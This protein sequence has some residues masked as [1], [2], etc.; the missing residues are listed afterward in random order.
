MCDKS[1][2]ELRSTPEVS[3]LEAGATKAN[4]EQLTWKG[5]IGEIAK[6]STL[7]LAVV[8]LFAYL[9]ALF[10]LRS[11]CGFFGIPPY[12]VNP[13]RPAIAWI[14]PHLISFLVIIVGG[15]LLGCFVV[16]FMTRPF[17]WLWGKIR[18]PPKKMPKRVE[19]PGSGRIILVYLFFASAF[20][21]VSVMADRLGTTD[22][23]SETDFLV[24]SLQPESSDGT[25]PNPTPRDHAEQ[26]DWVV[27]YSDGDL[28]VCAPILKE[29]KKGECSIGLRFIDRSTLIHSPARLV[30]SRPSICTAPQRPSFGRQLVGFF[31]TQDQPRVQR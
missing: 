15:Y 8:T 5:A 25:S 21:F 17:V 26:T 16:W 10:Y 2:T 23:A 7:L 19:I 1:H 22:A 29:T 30:T 6:V 27:V 11:Y 12:L 31:R 28:F 9:E 4:S 24:L 20:F 14:V 13:G 18:K 3:P